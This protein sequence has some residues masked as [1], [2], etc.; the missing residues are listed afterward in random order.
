MD[1]K[2]SP[3]KIKLST[4]VLIAITVFYMITII[5]FT[6][7]KKVGFLDVTGWLVNNAAHVP[8]FFILTILYLMCLNRLNI[9][10]FK[11][12]QVCALFC[13]MMFSLLVEYFQSY[14][15]YRTASFTDLFL[16]LIGVIVAIMFYKKY[17]CYFQNH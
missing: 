2:L 17:H 6:I 4:R 12:L 7:S 14:T 8:I 15:T 11:I 9:L 16:N 5:L 13:T 1:F 3:S 10:N